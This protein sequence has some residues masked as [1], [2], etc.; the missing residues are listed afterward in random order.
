M[1]KPIKIMDDLRFSPIF[2]NTHV[3]GLSVSLSSN[4]K[5]QPPKPP[6]TPPVASEVHDTL[7]SRTNI[8]FI[9]AK[10]GKISG[11]FRSKKIHISLE[12][13]W[14]AISLFPKI[15]VVFPQKWMVYNETPY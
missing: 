10:L 14:N 9:L 3:S 1:E 12:L 6:A 11:N 7:I 5:T 15:G 13:W 8:H 4:E 2:G